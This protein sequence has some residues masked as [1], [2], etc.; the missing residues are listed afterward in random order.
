MDV[1]SVFASS[2]TSAHSMPKTMVDGANATA[3]GA[4]GESHHEYN[5]H[6]NNNNNNNNNNSSSTDSPTDTS[7]GLDALAAAALKP[8]NED[9]SKQYPNHGQESHRSHQSRNQSHSHSPP[10]LHHACQDHSP[11]QRYE[12][13]PDMSLVQIIHVDILAAG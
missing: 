1:G 12:E 8:A 11:S 3:N 9:Y 4:S 10:I 2:P 5:N 6:S 13:D 7:S